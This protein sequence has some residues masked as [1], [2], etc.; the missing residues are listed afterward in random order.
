MARRRAS[1]HHGDLRRAL[2]DATLR[3]AET[4]GPAGVTLREAARLAGVSQT[5]PY[6]HF[7]DKTAMLAAASEEG[8]VILRQ[9]MEQAGAPFAGDPRRRIVEYGVAYV[10]FAVTHPAYFR[11]MYGHGSAAKAVTRELQARARETFQMFFQSVGECLARRILRRDDQRVLTYELWSLGHGLATLVLDRQTLH[12]D[13]DAANA[14]EHARAA[15]NALL[16][17]LSVGRSHG[18]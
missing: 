15:M 8:F 17:G 18:S 4:Q 6:R 3:L 16:S 10:R 7:A 14:P 12:L 5:A 9:A 13:V 11:L 1:Y 2:L